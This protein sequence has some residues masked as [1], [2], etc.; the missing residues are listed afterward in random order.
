MLSLSRAKGR[1]LDPGL[2]DQEMMVALSVGMFH[3]TSRISAAAPGIEPKLR[4]SEH[5]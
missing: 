2:K 3:G 1:R 4:A 5:T